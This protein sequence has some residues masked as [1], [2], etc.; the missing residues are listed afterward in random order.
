MARKSAKAQD[1]ENYKHD[2][3]KRVMIPTS[4]QQGFVEEDEARPIK[5]RW[6]RNPDLDPQLVWRGKDAEDGRD[7]Y[8]DAPPVYI[9]EKVHPRVIVERLRRETAARREAAS[10]MPDLF[11]DFNGR[12]EDL[13]ART[14]FY[15]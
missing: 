2:G 15:Q 4:E 3:A 1:V 12:P 9:Q 14:E 5:L 6:P 11:A 7:L 8:V 10:E 13:E